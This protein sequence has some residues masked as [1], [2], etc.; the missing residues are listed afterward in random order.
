MRFGFKHLWSKQK[1]CNVILSAGGVRVFAQIGALKAIEEAGWEI[2]NICG[3][4]GGAVIAFLYAS[5]MSIQDI[6]RK[7]IYFNCRKHVKWNLYRMG[8]GFFRFKNFG[9]YFSKC[10][11]LK[12]FFF[13]LSNPSI[14]NLP[15]G[16]TKLLI[17]LDPIKKLFEISFFGS[18]DLTFFFSFLTTLLY[19][20]N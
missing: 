3:V 6:E 12:S 4:S 16:K 18:N 20:F 2:E 19:N 8:S 13:K 1:K 10:L 5:G 15:F 7:A 9:E 11:I 17:S 14:F